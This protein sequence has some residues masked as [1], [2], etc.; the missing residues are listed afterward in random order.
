VTQQK[1]FSRVTAYQINFL[2]WLKALLF[3]FL[4]RCL[5][6]VGN[7]YLINSGAPAIVIG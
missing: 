7:R 3:Q 2:I 5:A 1:C 6:K 4:Q